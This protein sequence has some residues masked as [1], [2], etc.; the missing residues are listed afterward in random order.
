MDYKKSIAAY[1][2]HCNDKIKITEAFVGAQQA[3][4]LTKIIKI[5]AEE[6]VNHSRDKDRVLGKEDNSYWLNVKKE[7]VSNAK[8]EGIVKKMK[9]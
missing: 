5:D 4:G 6:H 1:E 3:G 9:Q 2:R 7:V 8:L